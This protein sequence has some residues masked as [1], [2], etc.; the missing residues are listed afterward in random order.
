MAQ[1]DSYRASYVRQ[2]ATKGEIEFREHAMENMGIRQIWM[3]DVL[4]AIASGKEIESQTFEDKDVRVLFQ[5]ST[6]D[7]PRFAVVVAADHPNVQVLTVFR[8]ADDNKYEYVEKQ[9]CWRRKK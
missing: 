8:F 9:N 4:E 3:D 6:C 2:K 1:N 5:E 7:M